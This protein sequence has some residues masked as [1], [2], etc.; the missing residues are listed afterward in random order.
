MLLKLAASPAPPRSL[1][2]RR[3]WI[4]ER[5]P[6]QLGQVTIAEQVRRAL[7][8]AARPQQG[9]EQPGDRTS[10]EEREARAEPY[11]KRDDR[12]GPIWQIVHGTT[13]PLR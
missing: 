10:R 7:A 6:R 11:S 4:T 8:L 3:G 1:L 5:W 12:Y 2:T 9:V 13:S